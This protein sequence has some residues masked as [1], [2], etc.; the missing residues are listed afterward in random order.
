M[1]LF[2]P[3]IPTAHYPVKRLSLGFSPCPNDTFVFHALV[4]HLA[5][6]SGIEFDPRLEDV[7]TLNRL[8]MEDR[9]DVTKVSFGALPYLLDDYL[10]LRS[11][12]ALG[13]GCGP[14]L[15]ARADDGSVPLQD[16]RI[17]IPGRFTTANLLLRL[18]CPEAAPG[19]E[20][21]YDRIMPAVAAGE[22]DAG[23]IIHESRFTYPSHGLRKLVD[24]GEWWE[25][26][27]GAP[28]PLGC[29]VLRRPLEHLADAIESAIRESVERAFADPSL[30]GEYVR[31]NAQE[32]SAD[33]TRRH[34]ELYVNRFSVDLGDEGE[35]AVHQLLDRARAASLTPSAATDP[36]A[37]T[38][39]R[40]I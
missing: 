13:R 4:H 36:F 10:L 3:S 9:L 24:L 22:Y 29:I 34:I 38:S 11:G 26:E 28:I 14:L 23:L 31:A 17:A 5:V 1:A 39:S 16:A 30:S 20:V 2:H 7:E 37:R 12:G 32:L 40:R 33:V 15:V 25:A 19:V 21:T 6:A 8:A 18:Y 27:T 35:A